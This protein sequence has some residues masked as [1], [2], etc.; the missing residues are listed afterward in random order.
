MHIPG[1][2]SH[3][4]AELTNRSWGFEVVFPWKLILFLGL[5]CLVSGAAF[6]SGLPSVQTDDRPK[7]RKSSVAVRQNPAVRDFFRERFS[8]SLLF[9]EKML[10]RFRVERALDHMIDLSTEK[11]LDLLADLHRAR[12]SVQEFMTP[13][14]L[15]MLRQEW[16]GGPFTGRDRSLRDQLER[17]LKKVEDVDKDLNS[18]LIFLRYTLRSPSKYS[19]GKKMPLPWKQV[20]EDIESII[21]AVKC[22]EDHIHEFYFPSDSSIS[23]KDLRAQPIPFLVDKIRKLTSRARKSLRNRR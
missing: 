21:L 20:L 17:R 6:G 23:V 15:N 3:V 9:E 2:R 18:H 8:E 1:S 5:V 7:P 16:P 11:V 13:T 4:S 22:L 12:D 19:V 14:V 10:G